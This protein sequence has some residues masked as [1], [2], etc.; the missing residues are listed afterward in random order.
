MYSESADWGEEPAGCSRRR[1]L[2]GGRHSQML[3]H[4]LIVE[5]GSTA[6]E[7]HQSP[8]VEV[9]P[10]SYRPVQEAV[11]YRGLSVSDGAAEAFD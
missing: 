9:L 4:R 3:I 10:K 5:T 1:E 2:D 8:S 6:K 7:H 11:K